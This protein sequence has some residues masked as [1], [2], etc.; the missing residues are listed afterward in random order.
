M[1]NKFEIIISGKDQATATIRRIGSAVAATDKAVSK[2][3]SSRAFRA[4][5]SGFDVVAR[6]AMEASRAVN[7]MLAGLAGAGTV[8][9][10]S[11]L[12]TGFGAASLE[13]MRTSQLVGMSVRDLQSWRGAASLAGVSAD[14]MTSGIQ[15][16]GMTMQD[17]LMG[18]NQ[19]ALAIL[20]QI[21]VQFRRTKDGAIDTSSALVQL[22]KVM[23]DP[24]MNPQSKQNLAERLGISGLMPLLVQG[25][26]AI[27]RYQDRI[28]ALGGVID[29]SG[30]RKGEQFG[31]R[32]EELK[33]ST[34]GLANTLGDK[35]VPVFDPIVAGMSEWIEKNREMIGTK[36]AEYV[37]EFSENAERSIPAIKEGAATVDGL[38]KSMGG[39]QSV[40]AA[41]LALKFPVAAA[42]AAGVYA[43]GKANEAMSGKGFSL[44]SWIYDVTHPN[45]GKLK[46]MSAEERKKLRYNDPRL[47]DYAAEIERMYGLPPGILNAV[48]NHGEKSGSNAVS[49]KGAKGVMQFM[50][51]TF[52]QY[53]GHRADPTDPVESINAAG[54][55]FK[56]LLRRYGG[57]VDAAIT[58]Y[59]GG[60]RQARKV[61]AGGE[62]T[63]DETRRYLDR[64]RTGMKAYSEKAPLVSQASTP[65]RQESP[66][67]AAP[68]QAKATIDININGAPSGTRAEAKAGPGVDANVR[69]SRAMP[70]GIF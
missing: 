64:V 23:S 22:S 6:S 10:I 70:E 4:A 30:V 12:A 55:Y 44:G 37:K 2:F 34:Q 27:Q 40:A 63:A 48:K 43:G 50:P 62:P 66:Q 16:L 52:R 47:N 58:E 15:A 28:Q 46:G 8:A 31:R 45:E 17:A 36:G 18:R 19:E 51:E 41:I 53:A 14:S 61:Q 67:S 69:I 57:D 20:A 21:G 26:E 38:V 13:I 33:A 65:S 54:R 60:V 68:A 5:A 9:G 32:M 49:P 3:G 39:Y 35:L 59:N 11:N 29:E 42:G 56:D 7:P 24:R 1:S 25:P